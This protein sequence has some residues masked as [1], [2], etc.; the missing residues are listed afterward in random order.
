MKK[1][2]WAE[3]AG[4]LAIGILGLYLQPISIPAWLWPVLFLS[5]DLG[6][7]GYLVNPRV[8]AFTYNVLHHK[9][10]AIVLLISGY[11][12]NQ[13]WLLFAGLLLFAHA[14]FDRFAGY[15]L[16]YPKGFKY[17][18]LGTIGKNK[19]SGEAPLTS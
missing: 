2:L 19:E 18:H 8:G 14:A 11:L 17:T 7:L 1:M 12:A 4:Q 6:M 3:E 15:G 5:P 10:I 16:K 13:P 9:G